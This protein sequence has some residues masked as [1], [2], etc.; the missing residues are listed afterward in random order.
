MGDVIPIRSN[1][2]NVEYILD[3]DV[4]VAVKHPSWS[5]RIM[6]NGDNIA[7]VDEETEE[8]FGELLADQFNAVM[9]CWLLI[10]DPKLVDD[11]S[12]DD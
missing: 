6:R 1:G 8:P 11:A 10:D 3:D 5:F 7:L 12:K 9:M 2:I 4:I